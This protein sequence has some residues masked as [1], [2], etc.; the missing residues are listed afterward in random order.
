MTFDVH[1]ITTNGTET[2]RPGI[3][4][5]DRAMKIPAPALRKGTISN[6]WVVDDEGRQCADL[7]TIKRHC[8]VQ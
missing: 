3:A 7:E 5:K 8:G 2:V 4:S 6:A 1:M